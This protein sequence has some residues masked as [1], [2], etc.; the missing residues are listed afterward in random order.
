[1]YQKILPPFTYFGSK[2]SI[3]DEIWNIVGNVDTYIEPFCGSAA[4][5]LGRPNIQPDTYYHEIIND[6]NG[7]ITNFFRAVKEAPSEVAKWADYPSSELDLHARCGWMLNREERLVWCLEDPDFY[8]PKIAGWWIWG[9][10]IWLGSGYME[11][12]TGS[13]YSN[14]AHLLKGEKSSGFSRQRQ[15][16]QPVKLRSKK[17]RE[18]GIENY[19]I[20]ISNR[21]KYVTVM[22][23]DWERAVCNGALFG[24]K[25]TKRFIFLDPPYD[26]STGRYK[27]LYNN[28][29]GSVAHDVRKWCLD[30]QNDEN[31][32]I[33]LCGYDEH[34]GLMND[35]WNKLE[36]AGP[37][38]MAAT[39]NENRHKEIIYFNINHVDLGL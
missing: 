1:M 3:A 25:N 28:N 26:I 5:L 10:S 29:D 15:V 30:H 11:I 17:I 13:C 27:R 39:K 19:I 20:S 21:L 2:S 8:D 12:G 37:K 34:D 36:W 35:T 23:G 9:A 31:T 4:V 7:F 18:I 22:C 33:A 6:C 32:I 16:L 14:G 38:G 24:N